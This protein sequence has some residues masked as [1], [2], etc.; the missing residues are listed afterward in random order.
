MMNSDASKGE[1]MLHNGG[2][3]LAKN[4]VIRFVVI[5]KTH[6]VII[7]HR[8]VFVGRSISQLLVASF[9]QLFFPVVNVIW[10][11]LT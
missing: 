4:P 11:T 5:C 8:C 10:H 2:V 9:H 6:A 3:T 1:F 7:L